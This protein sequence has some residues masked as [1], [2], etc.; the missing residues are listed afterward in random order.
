MSEK[1]DPVKVYEYLS[2]GKPVVAINLPELGKIRHLVYLAKNDK[3]FIELVNQALHDNN[4]QLKL[5]RVE[6]TQQNSWEKRITRL[7][8]V[9]S[10]EL[11]KRD[12]L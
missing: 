5:K 6:Y 1:V 4:Q 3:E 9:I 7:L 11:K 12:K 8:E 2:L 10:Y